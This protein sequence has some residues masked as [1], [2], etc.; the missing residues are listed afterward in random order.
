MLWTEHQKTAVRNPELDQLI[1]TK[2]LQHIEMD[3]QLGVELL[4]HLTATPHQAFC[5]GGMPLEWYDFTHDYGKAFAQAVSVCVS[6]HD[7]PLLKKVIHWASNNTLNC[8]SVPGRYC[9]QSAERLAQLNE[10]EILEKIYDVFYPEKDLTKLQRF[11]F[12]LGAGVSPET[13]ETVMRSAME[14]LA[15]DVLEWITP[16]AI[17]YHT[18]APD[19]TGLSPYT[20]LTKDLFYDYLPNPQY[21][22]V[23]VWWLN[24]TQQAEIESTLLFSR[25]KANE[26][27]IDVALQYLDADHFNNL[28]QKMSTTRSHLL[29]NVERE[30]SR[31]QR[32]NIN[33]S[34]D[35]IERPSTNH[36]SSPYSSKRKI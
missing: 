22:D 27:R 28:Q 32:I 33:A 8:V 30:I 15:W 7:M 13:I 6:H 1:D 5:P 4:Q 24:R 17:N 12:S 3:I 10:K 29:P 16:L 25:P 20:V 11:R 23:L 36:I 9:R 35:A 18:V 21:D 14:A 34:L 2:E 26:R 31:R 19:A